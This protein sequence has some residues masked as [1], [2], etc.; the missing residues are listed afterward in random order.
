MKLLV[1]SRWWSAVGVSL[2]SLGGDAS[3]QGPESVS[4]TLEQAIA[5]AL[6]RSQELRVAKLAVASSSQRVREAVGT[7]LPSVD[8]TVRY[9]RNLRVAEAFLP[10]FLFD[11]DAPPDELVPVRFGAD[12]TWSAQLS[13]TQPL[14]DATFLLG[15]GAAGRF[16]SLQEEA[17][18]GRA[19]E[20]ASAVRRGYYAA[21]LAR[22]DV[23]VTEESVRR[24]E[25]TLAET[26]ALER[27]GLASSY[28]VLRLEV[29]LSNL[30]PNLRRAVNAVAAAERALTVEMGL[31]PERPVHVAGR[32]HDMNLAS[33]EANPEPNAELL[34]LVG[35]RDA[36]AA[37]PAELWETARR[38][39][40]DLRQARLQRDLEKTRAAVERADFFP[41]LSAF[42]DYGIIAQENG[43]LNFFGETENQ[44]TRTAQVGLQVEIPIFAGFSRAARLEQ[45]QIAVRQ[46]ETRLHRLER[47]A[48]NQIQTAW[49][50]LEEAGLRAEAQGK[51]VDQ[52]RRGFEIASAQY[53]AGTSSQLDVIDAELALRESEFNYA[54]AVY[55]Y[56][57]AQ[58]DLDDAVGVVPVVDTPAAQDRAAGSRQANAQ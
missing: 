29:R 42:F 13:V 37:S 38:R 2:L 22:E 23:R 16:R 15:V 36:L 43:R 48:E 17:A 57:I 40:S 10:A 47:D 28:D 41:R 49:E 52:A 51:A 6:E 11:P 50:R 4:V 31:D 39:R 30:R 26:R 5:V 9:Q 32:L 35:Y 8:A 27:T 33:I 54:Q 18:R 1:W 14:F 34:R 56:L 46:T 24:F 53:L 25:E 7:L 21:L 12:N 44:R 45:Q 19:Q 58:A 20:V 55:D 3:A